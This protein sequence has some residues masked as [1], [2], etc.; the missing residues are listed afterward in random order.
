MPQSK[1]KKT[2]NKMET[3]AAAQLLQVLEKTV[4]PGKTNTRERKKERLV[5][6]LLSFVPFQIRMS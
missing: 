2:A 6:M 5:L 3:E 4:S 1:T